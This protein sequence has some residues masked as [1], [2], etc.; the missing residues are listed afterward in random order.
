MAFNGSEGEAISLNEAA[1]MTSAYRSANPNATRGH[2]MG[3]TI[4]NSILAQSGC[5][6][7][8]TYYGIDSS[9]QKQL[10]LVGVDANGD[11]MTSG[12]IADRA[13]PCPQLCSVANPLNA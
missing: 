12:I 9:G 6:G 10:V 11:D 2:F 3:S 4:L 13:V 1:T 5:K 7:I 8:R